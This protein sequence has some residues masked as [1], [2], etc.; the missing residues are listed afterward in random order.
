MCTNSAKLKS[1]TLPALTVI[2]MIPSQKAPVENER[3][4][5]VLAK[6]SNPKRIEEIVRRR[7]RGEPVASISS[8][9]GLSSTYIYSILSKLPKPGNK[10]PGK[11]SPSDEISQK[12]ELLIVMDYLELYPTQKIVA[13]QGKERTDEIITH[14]VAEKHGV[15]ADQV[16]DILC[17]VT[18]LHPRVSYFPLYTRI[19]KWKNENLATMRELSELAGTTVPRIS[20]I[21]N[22]FEHLP[23]EI[24]QRLQIETGLSLYEI[25]IDLLELDKECRNTDE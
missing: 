17:Y 13:E 10:C 7:L 20:K 9:M 1:E 11:N 16:Y 5:I 14:T 21:L 12:E 8:D 6:R 15:S 2:R 23:L 25:Y 18:M 19:G 22:G 4:N 24:A 3:E